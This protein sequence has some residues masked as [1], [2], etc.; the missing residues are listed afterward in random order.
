MVDYAA[1]AQFSTALNQTSC[2]RC[3]GVPV[4]GQLAA[5]VRTGWWGWGRWRFRN[6]NGDPFR[7]RCSLLGGASEF[8]TPI[9][10]LSN[11]CAVKFAPFLDQKPLRA[12]S[13]MRSR[14][15]AARFPTAIW[16]PKLGCA[17]CKVVVRE[18]VD[19]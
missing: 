7:R 16:G 5:I 8:L 10:I 17:H 4:F 1:I 19:G 3:L 6:G 15:T 14:H 11:G 2:L 12:T 13:S 18:A 9:S